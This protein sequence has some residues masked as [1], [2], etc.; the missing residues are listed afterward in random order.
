[1][2]SLTVPPD[3]SYAAL[4]AALVTDAA[5]RSG[6]DET[7]SSH[8]VE[9]AQ[10]AFLALVHDA[11]AESRDPL[12]VR[13]VSSARELCVIVDE[14]GLPMN[15]ADAANDP[16]LQRLSTL[17]DRVR[18]HRRG[19]RGSELVL[20]MDCKSPLGSDSSD[21]EA[22][23]EK[24]DVAPEAY[25]VRR[26]EPRDAD[27]VVRCFYE[28]YGYAY[29]NRSVYEPRRLVD[30]NRSGRYLSFVAAT[31][32]GEI[33]AHYALDHAPDAPSAEGCGAII[34]PRHR[35][36]GLLERIRSEAQRYA[37]ELGLEGFFSE[38]VTDHAA[39]QHESERFGARITSIA[40]GITPRTMLAKHMDL[41]ATKQRQSLT[42]YVKP[43]RDV[44]ARD[45]HFPPRHKA[46]LAAAYERVGIAHRPAAAQA[47]PSR[48]EIRTS[49]ARASRSAEVAV[50][51][52]GSDTAA[53][54]RQAIRD[55]R[56]LGGIDV[57][58]ALLPLE[59]AHCA[60]LVEALESEGLF[61]SGLLP[62][63]LDGRDALRMQ[64]PLTPIDCA[65]LTLASD[66]GRALLDYI[67]ADRDRVALAHA[68]P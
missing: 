30:L 68:G 58:F 45:V 4:V 20:A 48:G 50:V 54:V 46:A 19:Q 17:V 56:A 15:A 5:T 21:D 24:S 55:V 39:T 23:V 7:R 33:A 35:G 26:F 59:D 32:D 60:A 37:I 62:W 16:E 12:R 63:A 2:I 44:G 6:L 51:R 11:M 65:Q 52:A 41:S 34:A 40:L 67:V 31:P 10:I 49:I 14:H 42:Y 1:M 22:T 29:D 8:L 28:T 18:W 64:L 53:A 9:A 61:Y 66:E 43:L 25:V 3:A 57:V 38:P 36:K 27:G 47:I 13:T